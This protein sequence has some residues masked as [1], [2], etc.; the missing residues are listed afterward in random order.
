MAKA[1]RSKVKAAKSKAKTANNAKV[2]KP[3]KPKI[4]IGLPDAAPVMGRPIEY[5]A[6]FA[7]IAK[8]MCRLGA[9]D[10]EI[11]EEFGVATSTVWRWRSKHPD[12]CS[13][14][15]EGRKRLTIE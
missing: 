12:F 2:A 8:A 9:T 11:A 6:E 15:S 13:A 5:R 10:Y 1:T 3:G 14:L 4:A 7:K